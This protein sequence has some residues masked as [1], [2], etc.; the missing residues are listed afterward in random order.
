MK[1]ILLLL[2]LKMISIN[3]TFAADHIAYDEPSI[4]FNLTKD[5][6][7][8]PKSKYVV[9][10]D[11]NDEP[12]YEWYYISKNGEKILFHYKSP[13]GLQGFK[14]EFEDQSRCIGLRI[15]SHELHLREYPNIVDIVYPIEFSGL[16]TFTR[17]NLDFNDL[18]LCD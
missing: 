8:L 5:G 18:H 9:Y 1:F 12:L 15:S 16:V 10:I 3:H 13:Q 11:G 17:F 4:I 2:I 7:V 14:F 6:R